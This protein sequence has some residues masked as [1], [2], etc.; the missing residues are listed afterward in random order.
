MLVTEEK[1]M[2]SVEKNPEPGSSTPTCDLPFCLET[3]K[4]AYSSEIHTK[5]HLQIHQAHEM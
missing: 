2:S 1:G 4:Q 5:I 3:N